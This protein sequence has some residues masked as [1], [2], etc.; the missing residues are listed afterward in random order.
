MA[1]PPEGERRGGHD[2]GVGW[3]ESCPAG[4]DRVGWTGGV[5]PVPPDLDLTPCPVATPRELELSPLSSAPER[6]GLCLHHPHLGLVLAPRTSGV[7]LAC[8]PLGAPLLSPPP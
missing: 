4:V 5:G 7:V 8:L 6:E 3:L 1:E 2:T